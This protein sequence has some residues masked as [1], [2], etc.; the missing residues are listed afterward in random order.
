MVG[1]MWSAGRKL[2]K[3]IRNSGSLLFLEE[4]SPSGG[5]IMSFNVTSNGISSLGRQ[6]LVSQKC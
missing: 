6:N 1:E 2:V 5:K 4:H 3:D